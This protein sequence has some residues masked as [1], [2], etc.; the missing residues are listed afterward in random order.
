MEPP[1]SD[2]CTVAFQPPLE[3]ALCS[4]NFQLVFAYSYFV[5][6]LNSFFACFLV[7]HRRRPRTGKRRRG[8]GR[9][10]RGG[11][12]HAETITTTWRSVNFRRSIFR[13]IKR[14]CNKPRKFEIVF[15]FISS[16]FI[17][18]AIF[19]LQK[20]KTLELLMSLESRK[21]NMFE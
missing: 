12:F 7:A 13:L 21:H 18:P 9:G 14:N 4:G 11:S 8:R 20:Y 1:P 17:N 2:S 19:F 16:F 5:L 3:P 10:G 6:N 15:N